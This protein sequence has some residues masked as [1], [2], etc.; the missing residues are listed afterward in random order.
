[1]L[2][3]GLDYVF[4][5]ALWQLRQAQDVGPT[6]IVHPAVGATARRIRQSPELGLEAL[7]A[8]A[9]MSA[10]R[11]G[12]I[13]KQNM[14]VALSSYRNRV[15][16]ERARELLQQQGVTTLEAALASGFGSYAQFYRVFREETGLNPRQTLEK[17]ER[18][19]S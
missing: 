16:L 4:E 3:L 17:L 15:R 13:F 8:A 6:L 12:R 7:A 19:R 14:G 1:M 2:N 5:L 18:S 10:G 11:L 9:R